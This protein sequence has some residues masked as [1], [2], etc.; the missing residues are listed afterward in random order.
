MLLALEKTTGKQ[1]AEYKLPAAP[2]FDAL[3]AARGEL[4]I[5]LQNGDVLCFE[6]KAP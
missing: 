1:L 5:S 3:I 2:S 4:F 6:G